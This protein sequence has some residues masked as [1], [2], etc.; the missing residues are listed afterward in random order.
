M[1]IE[2]KIIAIIGLFILSILLFTNASAQEVKKEIILG[3]ETSLLTA[4]VWIA[5][6]KGYFQEEGLNV[7][8]IEFDS[9]KASF[10]AMLNQRNID[11]ATV[12]QTPIMFNSFNRKDF[13]I[14][15][16]MVNS[17]NDVKVLVRRDRGINN[18]SDLRGKKVAITKGS[19]GEFF[20][21]LFLLYKGVVSS[22][23]ETIDAKPSELPPALVEERVDAICTWE[24]H[25]IKAKQLLGK[26]A[27][28]MP[29][30]GIYREDFYFL[31]NKRF[32]KND[33]EALNKFLKAIEKSELFIKGNEKES[34]NIV[35]QR[36]QLNRNLTALIWHEFNFQLLLDQTILISLEDEARWAI[37]RGL[38]NKKEIPNYL[39]FIFMDALEQIKPK[40]VT[41]IR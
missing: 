14:I 3:C 27:L 25:I 23:V 32:I 26:K 11:I 30:K 10:A 29:S 5:Q 36:L 22:Q 16:A 8:I 9:G 33:S 7:K 20:L 41:I 18:P 35:S 31:A 24:P 1:K 40:A 39:D 21:D 2:W 15:A 37:K 19:T 6:N 4:P 38:T 13:A 28:V 12:A 34:I 17:D